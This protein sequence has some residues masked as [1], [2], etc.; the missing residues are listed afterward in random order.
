MHIVPLYNPDG[1]GTVQLWIIDRK[2][3]LT[4]LALGM[5]EFSVGTEK[6]KY[7][8]GAAAQ[9]SVEALGVPFI[10]LY[11]ANSFLAGAKFEVVSD[12]QMKS[13]FIRRNM[14]LNRHEIT[15]QNQNDLKIAGGEVESSLLFR[16][17]IKGEITMIGNFVFNIMGLMWLNF[18]IRAWDGFFYVLSKTDK[19]SNEGFTS[20]ITVQAEGSNPAGVQSQQKPTEPGEIAKQK[21]DAANK[22][23]VPPNPYVDQSDKPVDG[24][25]PGLSPGV[26][27]GG[28]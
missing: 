20:T 17:A 26:F 19:I 5:N 12:E 3:Y 24:T 8:S 23:T 6:S 9:S 18:G 11:D 2:R 13:I 21:V 15:G 14:E 7:G 27:G 22:P 4:R 16:S 1:P 28:A 10:S 25:V